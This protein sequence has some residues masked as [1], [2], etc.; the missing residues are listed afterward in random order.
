MKKIKEFFA[1]TISKGELSKF[2]NK[3]V[4]IGTELAYNLN[5]KEGDKLSSCHHLLSQHLSVVY[6]NKK[7]L[8]VAG[9]FNTG[10]LE[11]DQNI[12]FL[13]IEDALINI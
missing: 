13:S 2:G 11:F 10:F 4:F 5:L 7:V 6:L 9:I 8:L 12:I 3:N 1:K